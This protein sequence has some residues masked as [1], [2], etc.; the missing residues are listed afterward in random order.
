MNQNIPNE[1][2]KIWNVFS[3]FQYLYQQQSISML[4]IL[5]LM[6]VILSLL[7][8]Y[9]FTVNNLFEITLQSAVIA[10]IAA[11]ESFVIF[12]GGI[13]LSVGSVFA[14]SA[15]VGVLA[16]QLSGSVI[17]SLMASIGAG[18]FAGFCNGLAIIKLKIPPFVATLG[19]M[20]IA[21]G[22][23]LILCN[24]VPIYGLPREYLWI[25]QGRIAGIVPVPTIIV[26]LLFT[27]MYFVLRNTR[28]GRFTYSIGSNPEATRLSGI[29]VSSVTLGIFMISG[30][31]AAIAAVI[32]SARLG[33][34]QPASGNGYELLAI[35]S[36]FIGGASIYG[37]EGNIFASLIGALLVTTI[38]NG[39]NI[40]GVSAFYQY[41]VNGLIIIFAVSADQIRRKR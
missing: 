13:D 37:G 40:L 5:I 26:I 25:G 38:R 33:T 32:E 29:K 23:A 9:F 2:R 30:M 28:F 41:V 3:I 8:P 22:L 15:I 16:L 24:G 20:G 18:L 4:F 1:S 17:V 10:L 14:F 36:V 12:S 27:V 31:F 34:M 19:M 11:G 21:R 35:G 6:W 39:L 7:S